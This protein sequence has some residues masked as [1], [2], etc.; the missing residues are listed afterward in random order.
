M[1]S[2]LHPLYLILQRRIFG[3]LESGG[4][5]ADFG[6]KTCM[7]TNGLRQSYCAQVR[8][9]FYYLFTCWRHWRFVSFA[10]IFEYK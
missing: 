3:A 5:G 7:N 9:E 10:P 6:K 4:V 1:L 8:R 2:F